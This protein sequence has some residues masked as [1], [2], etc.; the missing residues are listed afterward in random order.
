MSRKSRP[1]PPPAIP[2]GVAAFAAEHG[3]TDYVAPLLELTRS[4]F[5]NTPI[6]VLVEE[7]AEDPDLRYIAFQVDVDGLTVDELVAAQQGWSAGLFQ[8]CPSTHAHF[9][10]LGT[11]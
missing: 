1:A 2:A 4:L 5:P 3:V 7:D 9:F 6:E 10:C 8:R 11:V